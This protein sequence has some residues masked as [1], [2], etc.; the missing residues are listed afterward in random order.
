MKRAILLDVACSRKYD[1]W[2][3]V[4]HYEGK[5]AMTRTSRTSTTH[6]QLHRLPDQMHRLHE[7]ADR[8]MMQCMMAWNR[9]HYG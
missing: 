3:V 7:A 8:A 6:G 4:V 2:E 9:A 5:R 1:D